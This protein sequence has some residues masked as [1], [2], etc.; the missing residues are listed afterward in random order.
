[1][2]ELLGADW[3]VCDKGY[4]ASGSG[5]DKCPVLFSTPKPGAKGSGDC[6]LE[7]WAIG[8][9]VGV[10]VGVPLLIIGCCLVRRKLRKLER[11]KQL[12]VR[13]QIEE[14]LNAV[15]EISYPMVIDSRRDIAEIGPEIDGLRL[16]TMPFECSERPS[17]FP[18]MVGARL[19]R[20]L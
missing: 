18:Y 13:R 5:C 8:L 6:E 2:N 10:S 1:M 11:L 14:A 17:H 15:S 7:K 19:A 9:I 3:C 4:Y 12:G 20:R 16:V